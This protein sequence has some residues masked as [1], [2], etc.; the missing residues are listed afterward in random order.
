MKVWA[1]IKNKYIELLWAALYFG[2]GAWF[3]KNELFD[4]PNNNPLLLSHISVLLAWIVSSS[5]IFRNHLSDSVLRHLFFPV[6]S[7]SI[8][9]I[10]GRM[11]FDF[12]QS[13]PWILHFRD[14]VANYANPQLYR[15]ADFLFHYMYPIG[16]A[17]LFMN[18]RGRMLTIFKNTGIF[19]PIVQYFLPTVA[20]LFWLVFI[21]FQGYAFSDVYLTDHIHPIQVCVITLLVPLLLTLPLHIGIIYKESA[22]N[23]TTYFKGLILASCCSICFLSLLA[24]R[25][26][27]LH[28]NLI[29]MTSLSISVILSLRFFM[30][31]SDKRFYLVLPVILSINIFSF[32]INEFHLWSTGGKEGIY[33]NSLYNTNIKHA[34][35]MH[36]IIKVIYYGVNIIGFYVYYCFLDLKD[37]YEQFKK[38][39]YYPLKV[40]FLNSIVFLL[41]VVLGV[42]DRYDI[43]KTDLDY[44]YFA[45]GLLFAVEL[46]LPLRQIFYKKNPDY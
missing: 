3:L 30:V 31:L 45:L 21:N 20:F 25:P 32:F 14:R 26:S 34:I 29:F 16:Y 8:C 37:L 38:I 36:Y 7:I 33:L 24:Y 1:L 35:D 17:N 23:P 10:V 18:N 40:L 42:F 43:E 11:F 19:S 6:F 41:M 15:L 9:I 4:D 22:V 44:I 12:D 28:Q 39:K 27:T 46:V 2:G 5:F 13:S